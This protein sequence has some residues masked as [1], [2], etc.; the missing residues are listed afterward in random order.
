MPA[1]K[2]EKRFRKK[3]SD[4]SVEKRRVGPS[5]TELAGDDSSGSHD[6]GAPQSPSSVPDNN[7]TQQAPTAEN[8]QVFGAAVAR[9]LRDGDGFL[10]GYSLKE[11]KREERAKRKLEKKRLK[12]K[13]A[14]EVDGGQ[15]YVSESSESEASEDEA[16]KKRRLRE[17]KELQKHILNQ[18]H[19]REVATSLRP[20]YE[21]SLRRVATKG[22]VRLFNAVAAAQKSKEEVVE[23][24]NAKRDSG[25]LAEALP[26]TKEQKKSTQEEVTRSKFLEML[27]KGGESKTVLEADAKK[28]RESAP[29]VKKAR[30]KK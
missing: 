7:D 3:L 4:L 16:T 10:G 18:A 5:E 14:F 30:H 6:D 24:P 13:R 29:P 19:G 9:V 23:Q 1:R 12:R 22:V 17:K 2:G 25:Q 15:G 21:K 20:D 26:K 11:Q 8:S 27:R 28:L